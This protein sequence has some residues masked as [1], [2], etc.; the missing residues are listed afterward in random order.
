MKGFLVKDYRLLLAQRNLLFIIPIGI[1]F[2]FTNDTPVMGISYT[3]YV[4][5]F[6]CTSLLAYDTFDNG[7]VFLMTQPGGRKAY[8]TEKYLFVISN[9]VLAA[10]ILS[11]IGSILEFS[12]GKGIIAVQETMIGTL[13]LCSLALAFAFII[14]PLQLKFGPEKSR[15]VMLLVFAI[16]FLGSSAIGV[17]AEKLNID[18]EA[19]MEALEQ[20]SLTMVTLA[21]LFLVFLLA[22]TSWFISQKI[23]NRMEF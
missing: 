23:M 6:F 15:I 3:L 20:I 10:I 21:I 8:V 1:I 12:R 14:L 18:P 19:F 22:V 16:F 13:L 17:L 9:A 7:M 2:M 5:T 11:T 4:L